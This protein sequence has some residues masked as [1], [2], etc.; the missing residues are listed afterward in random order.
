M[1][2]WNRL[3][4]QRELIVELVEEL[5]HEISYRGI[6]RL[7]QITIQAL[8]DLGLMAIR[9]VGWSTPS[10]YKEIADVLRDKNIL[11]EEKAGILR[12]L[13]GLRNIL[14]HMYTRVDRDIVLEAREK[15]VVDAISIA[16]D[17]LE[18]IKGRVDDPGSDDTRLREIIEFLRNRLQGRVKAVYIFGGLVK[19]YKLKGDIDI[20][21]YLGYK[22]DPYELGDIV[23]NIYD[24]PGFTESQVDVHCLDIESPDIVLEALNGIPVFIEDPVELLEFYIKTLKE[25][26][27]LEI[28][29]NKT[30]LS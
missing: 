9:A 25:K 12:A 1:I 17:I 16:D 29:L 10:K 22:P 7:I 8:L 27:D 30:A 24:L 3:L 2:V 23:S 4:K 14:V 6:E 26:I 19:G 20:A 15:L 11:S 21:I 13:A 28:D 18:G 5:K